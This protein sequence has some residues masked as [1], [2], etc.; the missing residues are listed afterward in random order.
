MY[1]VCKSNLSWKGRNG[2]T[3]ICE[4]EGGGD[5]NDEPIALDLV[6]KMVALSAD[7]NDEVEIVK[8][9]ES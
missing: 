2:W 4:K 1:K 6:C 3:A 7:K 5:S 8:A 9:P